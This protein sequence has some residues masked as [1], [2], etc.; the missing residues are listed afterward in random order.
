M[1]ENIYRHVEK[2]MPAHEAARKG[3]QEVGFTIISIS[4]RWSRCSFRCC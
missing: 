3:A 4:C 2:G 1:L